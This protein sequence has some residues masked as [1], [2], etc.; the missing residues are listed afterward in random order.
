MRNYAIQGIKVGQIT[1]TNKNDEHLPV[2]S[3]AILKGCKDLKLSHKK[4]K[5]EGQ[6]P[7]DPD[8]QHQQRP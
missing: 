5:K 1:F 2:M 7:A 3:D 8:I 4:E 6:K